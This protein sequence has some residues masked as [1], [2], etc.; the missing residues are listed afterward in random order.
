[1]EREKLDN[2]V[3]EVIEDLKNKTEMIF[4]AAETPDIMARE[5]LKE[6]RDKATAVL[7]KAVNAIE[8]ACEGDYDPKQIVEGLKVAI[9]RSQELYE[10]TMEQ[11][12]EIKGIKTDDP[13]ETDPDPLFPGEE[14]N[15]QEEVSVNEENIC[16]EETEEGKESMDE[17]SVMAHEVLAGWIVP[18]SENK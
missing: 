1:M 17:V 12:S 6:V 14:E 7:T 5:P 10:R 11:I 2:L 18:E 8:N 9:D 4:A 13:D 16:E 3:K 15:V